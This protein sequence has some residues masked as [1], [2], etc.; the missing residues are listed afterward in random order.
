MRQ[1]PTVVRERLIAAPPESI[2][3]LVEDPDRMGTWFTFAERFEVLE[4]RGL[5]RRQR[6]HGHWGKQRSEIDQRIVA[7]E[8]PSRLAW[9]HEAERLDGKPAPRFA[10]ETIFTIELTPQPGGTRVRMTSAQTPAGPLQGA[11]MRV[12]G[13]RQV[14]QEMDRSLDALANRLR[15][16]VG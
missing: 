10:A 1:M 4:G 2:W 5:G 6:L 8:P 11:V 13:T 7:Y 3:P 9:G 15:D 16:L 12:F 14:A